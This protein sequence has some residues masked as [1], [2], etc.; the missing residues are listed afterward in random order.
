VTLKVVALIHY[1]A[2]KLFLK[3]MRHYRKPAPPLSEISR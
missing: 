3:G 1:Q 2:V